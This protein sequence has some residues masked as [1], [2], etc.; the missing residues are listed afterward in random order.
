MFGMSAL[1]TLKCI[2]PAVFHTLVQLLLLLL[3]TVFSRYWSSLLVSLLPFCISP[4]R[5][6]LERSL[7]RNLCT[8]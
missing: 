3:G 8:C 1:L 4:L 5:P 6:T 7:L 2:D